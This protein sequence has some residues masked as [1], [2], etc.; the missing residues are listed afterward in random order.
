MSEL[1]HIF[2][3]LKKGIIK[4]A[5]YNILLNTEEEAFI[6]FMNH[7]HL[8]TELNF[9]SLLK[10]YIPDKKYPAI[11]ITGTKCELNCAH[12]DK[13]YLNGMIQISNKEELE[14]YLFTLYFNDGI[15]ALISGGCD[16][17]GS[18]PLLNFLDIIKKIKKNT[19]LIINTH[20]GLLNKK[21][22]MSL[23]DANVD[24]VSFDI[25]IDEEI[26]QN[27]YHLKKN[28]ND[29]RNAVELLKSFN[30]NVVP[31]ICI[32][33]YY[34]ELH[35]EIESLKFI[36]DMQINPSII[37]FI[38]LI[39]PKISGKIKK[40]FKTPK[41]FD[42]AKII[43][44]ARFLFPKTEISLGCMR[45]KKDVR[46]EIEKLAIKAGINR[47]VLPSKKTLLWVKENYEN[48]EMQYY[49]ACCAI[50]KELEKT[51]KNKSSSIRK[52]FRI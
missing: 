5:D 38:V 12:C 4:W 37:V 7:A 9:G 30:L 28:I 34:G 13:K 44:L 47:L 22:A 11:S 14:E 48:I 46:E 2:N 10:I 40:G 41:P 29:Y 17:D 45:P 19:N 15:G 35:K 27:I 1:K 26:I 36:K 16:Q 49:S 20:T 3:D 31:H 52:S 8:L 18:V 42:V 21:T 23:A 6:P 24:I 33:L 50:P 25:N 39:P 43:T 51:V 32:G